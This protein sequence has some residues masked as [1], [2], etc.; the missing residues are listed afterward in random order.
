MP[1]HFTCLYC[2]SIIASVTEE[3]MTPSPEECYTNSR[4]PIPNLGWFCSQDCALWFEKKHNVT[5]A[6]TTEGKIDYYAESM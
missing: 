5:F 1:T 6:R 3:M 4:V 2:H